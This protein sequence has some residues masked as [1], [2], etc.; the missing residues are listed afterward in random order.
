LIST[1]SI[2]TRQ[3]G[4]PSRLLR[5]VRNDV[6]AYR[7]GVLA[8]LRSLATDSVAWYLA[9][10]VVLSQVVDAL[11]TLLALAINLP[12]ANPLSAAVIQ[13]WGVPGLLGEKVVIASVVVWNMAR[14]RGRGA[15][16]LGVL[17]A[18]I[19]F[20]AAAWNVHLLF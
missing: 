9:V 10:V 16:A 13:R 15:W 1:V 6:I 5:G 18:L 14:L 7:S 11:S 17:A 3:A 12:E 19:G 8:D 20:A 4:V 2:S